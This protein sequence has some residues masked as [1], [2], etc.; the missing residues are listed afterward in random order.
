MVTRGFRQ[1]LVVVAI[2][3]LAT[4]GHGA[5]GRPS[6]RPIPCFAGPET[7]W[8]SWRA[9]STSAA[10]VK[11][12]KCC[13]IAGAYL[14]SMRGTPMTCSSP[15]GL[16]PRRIG[17]SSWTSGGGL[18]R[19]KRPNSPGPKGFERDRFARLIRYRGDTQ[20]EWRSYAPDALQIA[21]AFTDGINAYLDHLGNRL[22]IEFQLLGLRPKKWK[23]ADCVG[24]TSVLAVAMNLEQEVARAEL[25]A[26]V[27]A[28]LAQKIMPTDPPAIR[29]PG[30]WPGPV[31]RQPPTCS[32]ATRPPY[33][34]CSSSPTREAATTG[35][36]AAR[37]RRR[38]SRCWPATRIAAISLPSLRY[39]VHLNA[40]G[41]NVIGAGEPALPGVAIGHNERIAWAFT[42]VTT[43]Q[44]DLVVEQT[45]SAGFPP[46]S[47]RRRLAADGSRARASLRSRPRTGR[48]SNCASRATDR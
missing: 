9:Q 43:D 14:T 38:E 25:V 26:T 22:P 31:G 2:L 32:P 36:S 16:S 45:R 21:T 34:G 41:W 30:R 29:R 27:G 24:R 4:A 8:R 10:C 37:F 39:V 12:S 19:V 48:R 6:W 47:G 5:S 23:P 42:V 1:W 11:K 15:R 44:A 3:M 7:C 46:L 17:Y 28:E 13:A 20:R 33:P 40:P 18:P 35:P